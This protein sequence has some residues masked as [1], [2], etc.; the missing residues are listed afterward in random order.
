MPKRS[1]PSARGAAKWR[2]AQCVVMPTARSRSVVAAPAGRH[3]SR[4]IAMCLDVCL[5]AGAATTDLERAVG[6][7]T[8][9]A[10]RHLAAPRAEG[11]LRFGIAQG[12]THR[13]LRTRSIEEV[14]ALPFD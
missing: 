1:C 4:H 2:V 3:T 5:P 13:E 8:H 10:T 14:T 7:T 11:Q 12:A 9:W 6:I